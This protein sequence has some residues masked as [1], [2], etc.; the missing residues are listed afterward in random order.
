M[1]ATMSLNSLSYNLS[2]TS[3]ST[4]LGHDS[5]STDDLFLPKGRSSGGKLSPGVGSGLDYRLNINRLLLLYYF[6]HNLFNPLM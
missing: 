4:S 1:S 2:H 6:R 5:C 3:F